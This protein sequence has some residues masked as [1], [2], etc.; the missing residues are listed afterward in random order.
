MKDG[1]WEQHFPSNNA[2]IAAVIQW[3]TS[4]GADFYEPDIQVLVHHW[5]KCT[6]SGGNYVEK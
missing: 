5:Q 1:L 4:A 2:I 3:A 6:A